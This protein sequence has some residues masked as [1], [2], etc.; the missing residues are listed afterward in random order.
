MLAAMSL[1]SEF[2]GIKTGI[3]AVESPNNEYWDFET[4][5]SVLLVAQGVDWANAK[6]W[7][8]GATAAKHPWLGPIDE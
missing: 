5:C 4:C 2:F 3:D 6:V 8:I 1:V 7:R